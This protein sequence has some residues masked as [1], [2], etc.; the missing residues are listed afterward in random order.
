MAIA[1]STVEAAIVAWFEAAVGGSIP[2]SWAGQKMPTAAATYVKLQLSGL[3]SPGRDWL[4]YEDAAVPAPGA[5]LVAKVRG[6]RAVT[7][8]ATAYAT[9]AHGASMA[10]ALLDT[11]RSM[12]SLPA[13]HAA[14]R[15]AGVAVAGFEPIVAVDGLVGVATFEPRGVL[16]CQ[17]N[18][19]SEVTEFASYI[20]TA[21][22]T[23]LIDGST[24]TEDVGG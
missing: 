2:V 14:L 3:R 18:L 21:E 20:E 4:Q 8:T 6:P 9:P 22:V 24:F 7:L 16:T 13:R 19:A 12:S 11:A 15:A 17:I 10:V 23:S 1:W 5:E